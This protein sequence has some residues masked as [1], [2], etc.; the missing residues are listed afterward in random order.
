MA[1]KLKTKFLVPILLLQFVAL[2]ALGFIGYRFSSD[3]LRQNAEKQFGTT[4]N[5]VY[6]RIEDTLN[7]RITKTELLLKNPIFIKYSV[8]PHYKSD[9]D[10]EVFNFQKGNGLVL[11]EPEVGGLVNYPIGLLAGEGGLQIIDT[12]IFPSEEYIGLDGVVRQHV[13]LGG[14]ND[15][16]FEIDDEFKLSRKHRPWFQAAKE[17]N[18]SVSRPDKQKVF[19]REY[20][21]ISISNEE[22]PVEKDLITIAM[23]HKIGDRTVG[24][25]MVTTTPQFIYDALPKDDSKYLLVLT[26][27]SGNMIASTGN[28]SIEPEIS[29]SS[30]SEMLHEKQGEVLD[31]GEYLTMYRSCPI[32]GWN[33]AIYGKKSDIYGLIYALRN[34]IFLI[35]AIS[36]AIMGLIVFLII[37]KLLSPILK[38]TSAS[39]RIAAGE[40]GVVIDKEEDDEIGSL[41]DS[42]NKMSVSTQQMH[43]RLSRVNF[44]RQ[45]LLQIIS[46]E[47]RTPLN[48][49]VGFYD[50]INDDVV[51][52]GSDDFTDC[53]KGLGKSIDRY[54]ILVERLTKTTAVMTDQMQADDGVNVEA[55]NL[56]DA[57]S[58]SVN[59]AKK[60]KENISC[61]I[62]DSEFEGIEVSCPMDALKLV[63][64]EALSNA[65]KYSD[66]EKD[67]RVVVSAYESNA[68]I[69]IHDDGEGIPDEY[70]GEV[71]EPFFEVK[72]SKQHF[73]SR[74]KQGGGGLG[75]GLSIISSVTKRYQGNFEIKSERGKGTSL[76][77][78]IPRA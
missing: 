27:G 23:P 75:L 43:D 77:I 56:V 25:L 38:L 29:K 3:I 7:T 48:A 18:L 24:V 32:S 65:I 9:V 72:D 15:A 46:H 62:G 22:R 66:E 50:L 67:V 59:D 76:F 60:H 47:L 36:I 17:G 63:I 53:F 42:F 69:E 14:S 64:A 12:G 2:G 33:I 49:I 73:T 31:E 57:I 41:T 6:D 39:N 8:G 13:Y 16:D 52:P 78:S 68:T 70:I 11:G 51:E 40:L 45:Q 61:N 54:K 28:E 26:D 30:E 5:T 37:K 21:P 58:I 1:R 71:V 35:M 74:Y 19:L 34:N 10:V 20:D 4:I 55:C 44:V